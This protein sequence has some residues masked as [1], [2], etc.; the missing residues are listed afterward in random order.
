MMTYALG[1]GLDPVDMAVVR[2][3]VARASQDDYR[4]MTIISGI[5]ESAPFQSRTKLE[6]PETVGT[7][8]LADTRVN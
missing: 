7:V 8:A 4:F 3:I 1:R 5:V 6:E 2:D